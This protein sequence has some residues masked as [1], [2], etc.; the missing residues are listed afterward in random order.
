MTR[1]RKTYRW[2]FRHGEAEKARM[3]EERYRLHGVVAQ[4][5][6]NRGLALEH[7][8]LISFMR[9]QLG[10]LHDPFLMA[11]MAKGV[12][13]M[14]EA[15]HRGECVAVFGDYDADGMT[16]TSV[17]MR[18]LQHAG[19]N[20]LYY[21]PHR[22]DEGY[23]LNLPALEMLA[24][25]GV[26]LVITVDN[27]I[28]GVEQVRRAAELGLEVIITD[29]HQPGDEL[30]PALAVINPSRRDCTYPCKHLTGV[31]VA[32]KFIHA[33]LKTL[34]R[35]SDE[36]IAF[37]RSLLDLVAIGTVADFAPL[38]GENRVLVSHGLAQI[39]KSENV[40]LVAL[41]THLKLNGAITATHVGFQIAPRLNAA[42]RTS[43]AEIGVRLLTT[44]DPEEARTIV[45]ELEKCNQNRKHVEGRIFEESM[46]FVRDQINLDEERVVVVD[47]HGWHL[48]VIGIV[49]SRIMEQVDRP[50][51][52]L[53]HKAD[54]VKGSARSFG[55]F[56]LFEALTSCGHLL[57]AYGGHPHAA[58][59]TLP[60]ENVAAFR[61]AINAHAREGY[62]TEPM[63]QPLVID[64][65][66]DCRHLCLEMMDQ[67]GYLEPFGQSNPH[68]IFASR[69]L[70]L[71]SQPR[72]VGEK[73]LKMQFSQQ[74]TIVEGI[75]FNMGYLARDL[76]GAVGAHIDVAFS[77]TVSRF[78]A[79]PRVELDVKDVRLLTL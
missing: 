18:G 54:C 49:A 32:F 5:I 33:L 51:V 29:H 36:S 8:A 40:G 55:A 3:L 45:A 7:D 58:G 67:L 60:A 73:H 43:H 52:V 31:G 17:M 48:G 6:A 41:R 44:D 2:E 53:T 69:G 77:P 79:E 22:V 42:G 16:S 27:G 74:G 19:A 75:G 71:H 46:D 64:A 38:V 1:A 28:S 24:A 4:V 15:I 35:P 78:W 21:V 66:I 11:D 63:I 20:C 76:N 68:P 56:N 26:K 13:R 65:E 62:G 25:R 61:A 39:A 72:V 23:G 47:G 9:P 34:G 30:P 12:N 57:T 59:M 10:S 70:K 37:L 50:V 14:A